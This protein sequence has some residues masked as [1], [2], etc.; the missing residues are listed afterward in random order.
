V[1]TDGWDPVQYDRFRDERRQP[2]FDLLSLVRPVP[3]GRVIDLGCGTGELTAWLHRSL[4]AAETIGIDRSPAML[5]DSSRWAGDGVRFA[6]REISTFPD[7]DG[8]D[9]AFDVVFANAS[10][11]WVDDHERLLTQLTSALGPQGQL[12]FQVPANFGHPSHAVAAAVAA[13]PPFADALA[14]H[15]DPNP[16]RRALLAPESYSVALHRLGF[17]EQ[18]VRLQVYGHVLEST[19]TVVEWVKGTLLTPFR[20]GLDERSYEA[21]L[22]R[23]R[24]RLVAEL[25]D[26]RPYFYPFSRILVW[27]QRPWSV[28]ASE[29]TRWRNSASRYQGRRARRAGGRWP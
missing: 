18:H 13:E 8:A 23:Y 20:E 25:G 1:A 7:R 29:A 12:A 24:T 27:G 17:T 21:F 5:A 4:E 3:G 11:Q 14:G 26:H 2:F 6:P 9:G 15:P 28:V 10:L 19:E 22:E 16:G